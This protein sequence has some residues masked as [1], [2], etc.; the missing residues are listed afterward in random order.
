MK[1]GGE[2]LRLWSEKNNRKTLGVK[3][4]SITGKKMG[5]S[6]PEKRHHSS[7]GESTETLHQRYLGLDAQA[8][9]N[10]IP[11]PSSEIK[12]IGGKEEG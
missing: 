8:R 4:F 6:V 10:V 3:C 12:K 2:G 11:I 7:Q 1:K 9:N 5:Q